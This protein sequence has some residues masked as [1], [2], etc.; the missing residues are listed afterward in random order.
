MAVITTRNQKGAALTFSEV[1]ANF[2][3]LNNDIA[4]LSSSVYTAVPVGTVISFAGFSPPGG[5]LKANGDT[6]TNGLGTVQGV[7]AN[8]AALYAVLG[9]PGR[10]PD[11]RGEFVRGADD[12]RGV[13]PSRAIGSLQGGSFQ[14]HDHPISDPGHAHGAADLGHSHSYARSGDNNQVLQGGQAGQCNSG[15][16]PSNTDPGAANIVVYPHGTN[17]AVQAA[18][19][20]ETRPRNVALLYCIKY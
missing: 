3:A 5:W 16:F 19:G 18:G 6:V 12:G 2:V 7:T 20:S 17:I 15:V 8:F 9:A 1:D 4:N 11:L 14:S 13:D 10:L